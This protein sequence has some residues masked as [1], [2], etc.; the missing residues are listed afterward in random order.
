MRDVTR[1]NGGWRTWGSAAGAACALVLAG[2][3][4][5][6]TRANA[7]GG[8]SPSTT[9]N[10]LFNTDAYFQ[11]LGRLAAGDPMPFIGTVAAVRGPGDSTVALL[12]LSLENRAFSFQREP[13]G[14]SAK[15][16]VD[17]VW[18]REN[19]P[20]VV[21]GEEQTIRVA[22]FRETLRQN[23]SVLYQ[24]AFRLMPGTYRVTVT[25][26]DPG[27]G[28]ANQTGVTLILPAYRPGSVSAPII[29]YQ[30]K[31]RRE[32][33]AQPQLVLNPRGTVAY[34]GDTLLAYV[35]GYDFKQATNV[36]FE[37][38]GP[39]DSVLYRDSLRFL[40]GR[41]VESQ[42]VKVRPDSLVLGELALVVGGAPTAS[43]KTVALVSFSEDLVLTDFDEMLSL[44]RFFGTDRQIKEMREAP[45][46]ERGRLWRQFW[47][48]TDPNRATPE[49]EAL[50][51]YFA[52]IA[53]A[54][55]MFRDEGMPGWRTD[56]GE[57][58]VAL[59]EPD[60]VVESSPAT[61]ASQGRV[62]RWTYAT[63]RVALYFSD[64]G[65]GRLRLTQQS[66]AEFERL[67]QRVR[68]PGA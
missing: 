18:S 53:V 33:N 45:A 2:C 56:R 8:P 12:A 66:R 5:G 17:V 48:E 42:A 15:Y 43:N 1:R 57:V 14:F 58:F 31:G 46:A 20:P 34:G 61:S 62:V 28:N 24:R 40:G 30:A 59:G 50:E 3:G 68:R 16:R 44:L 7:P 65:F 41:A 29:A 4:G 60:E 11:K 63:Y 10:Q 21:S 23:E 55:R 38:L 19:T 13:G 47:Q 35:E 32:T 52:R 25:V 54:N 9:L 39:R 49:N 36:P 6:A 27:S 26:R 51:A 22:T 67:V 64:R 37:I